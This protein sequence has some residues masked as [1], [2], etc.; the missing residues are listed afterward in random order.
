MSRPVEPEGYNTS[1]RPAVE[2]QRL[3]LGLMSGLTSYITFAKFR[4]IG[5]LRVKFGYTRTRDLP[6]RP[7]PYQYNVY[8]THTVTRPA[9]TSRVRVN[10]RVRV[11][12]QS[13]SPQL[14]STNRLEH[15]KVRPGTH[16]F[17][18]KSATLARR[19]RPGSVQRLR[20]GVQMCAQDGS[21]ISVYLLPTR[22][23]H[24]WPSPSP[25]GWPWSSRF[26]TCE[27]CFIR[28]TFICIRRPFELE[29]TSCLP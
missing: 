10:P 25:I 12:P 20:P 5:L 21:W 15:A 9:G 11:Y 7:D 16:S 14:G 6:T 26:P 24:L 27:T 22:L 1:N 23:Q 13:P 2:G 17:P 29:L 8:P 19:C 3:Y 4:P 28:K 18:A